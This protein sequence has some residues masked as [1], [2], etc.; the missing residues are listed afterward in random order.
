M[1]VYV[2]CALLPRATIVREDVRDQVIEPT[3]LAKNG[4]AL[5]GRVRSIRT[6]GKASLRDLCRR[7]SLKVRWR[8]LSTSEESEVRFAGEATIV[9]VDEPSSIMIGG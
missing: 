7:S 2:T 4:Y 9:S 3:Y 8:T 6:S 5:A 1:G